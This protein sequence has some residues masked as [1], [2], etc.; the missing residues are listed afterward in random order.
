M[1]DIVIPTLMRSDK[2][3]FEYSLSEANASSKIKQIFVIDNTTDKLFKC[4]LP[5][6][7]ILN[8]N[9]NMYVNPAWNLG[10][11]LSDS[12]NVIIMNDDIACCKEN[13]DY[14]DEILN[15]GDCGLCSIN[16]IR[17]ETLREYIEKQKE[18]YYEIKTN[19][20]FGNPDNNKTGWF[21]GIK[22]KLW[23]N[24]PPSI[25]IIYGD[26]LI[27]MRIRKLGYS[28]KNITNTTIGHLE[29]KTVNQVMGDIISQVNKDIYEFNNLK[30][31]YLEDDSY[32][33][34]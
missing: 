32:E 22:R 11:N 6:V 7:Q 29:S 14:V 13:Y 8:H 25:K 17:I 10:V 3:V 2:D 15:T 18:M 34:Q 1:I 20:V 4:D 9:E 19:E 31:F 28:T 26:D 24:I 23:K 30:T 33:N 12:D 16:S 21:F 27:Y 5:K